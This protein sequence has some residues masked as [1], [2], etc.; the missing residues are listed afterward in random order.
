MNSCCGGK[1]NGQ[2]HLPVRSSPSQLHPQVKDAPSRGQRRHWYLVHERQRLLR[3][4]LLLFGQIFQHLLH[5]LLIVL[6][7]ADNIWR[8]NRKHAQPLRTHTQTRLWRSS[9]LTRGQVNV[10]GS[11]CGQQGALHQRGITSRQGCRQTH[12]RLRSPK[13]GVKRSRWRVTDLV[14][15]AGGTT[16]GFSCSDHRN[17]KCLRGRL[18]MLELIQ[19]NLNS[20]QISSTDPASW[21]NLERSP[22]CCALGPAG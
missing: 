21:R 12:T 15:C 6:H 18:K 14:G 8:R 11:V 10:E 17:T 7:L 4:L 9:A 19:N 22:G 20:G 13:T 2:R 3:A 5:L 16:S 1:S